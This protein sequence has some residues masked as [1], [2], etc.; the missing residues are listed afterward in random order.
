VENSRALSPA[1]S[2]AALRARIGR[3]L[4]EVESRTRR[5]PPIDIMARMNAIRSKVAA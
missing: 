4:G 3:H 2:L 1:E 5:R